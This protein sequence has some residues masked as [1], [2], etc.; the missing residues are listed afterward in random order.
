MAKFSVRN[1]SR[2]DASGILHC[3]G[4]AFAEYRSRYT[5][6]GFADTVLTRR[7]LRKRFDNM[8]VLVAVDLSG[9]IIGT[10][11]YKLE[12]HGEAHLRGM[13]VLPEWRGHK[14][15]SD[16]LEKAESE[17]REL[18]CRAITLDTTRP[19]QRAIRFYEKRGFRAT[20][21]AGSFFG[22]DLLAYRK[23]I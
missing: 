13:A 12:D 15:A 6:G 4:Q 11:A 22:M 9:Q 7:S 14:V 20:G 21:K 18:R 3:L 17:L 2:A 16:L 10:I 23:E 5:R 8:T 19:L 1:A